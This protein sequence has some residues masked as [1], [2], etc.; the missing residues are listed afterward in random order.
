MTTKRTFDW[1]DIGDGVYELFSPGSAILRCALPQTT[2]PDLAEL[3]FT[4]RVDKGGRIKRAWW[5]KEEDI[6]YLIA[7]L[8]DVK[9]KVFPK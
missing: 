9:E 8:Q 2:N 6:D 3:E 7:A 5:V 1:R 4:A